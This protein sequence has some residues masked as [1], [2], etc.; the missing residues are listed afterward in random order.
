VE[1][2]VSSTQADEQG[3]RVLAIISTFNEGDVI[4]H[5]IRH[6]VDN[7]VEVYVIDNRSTDD[8]VVE[9]RK[10]LGR[11]VLEVERFPGQGGDGLFRWQ[12]I[13]DRKLVVAGDI[14]PDW[15]LHHDADE[16]RYSPWPNTH[17]REAVAL[18]DRHGFNA[19]DF[20]L[21]NF[22]PV[23]DDF[24][25]GEDPNVYFTRYADGPERDRVQ[26]K[27]WKWNADSA[28]LDGGHDVQLPGKK[29]FPIRFILCHYPIRGQAHGSRKV[30]D[31]R[32]GR[33]V[34][35]ERAIGWHIQYDE[36]ESPGHVF[37][38][39]PA[40]LRSFDLDSIRLDV[41]LEQSRSEVVELKTPRPSPG[42]QYDGVL[43]VAGPGEIS[44][45]AWSSAAPDDP[46][47]VDLWASDELLATVR[48][49]LFREDLQQSGIG[50]GRHAFTF[51]LPPA[52]RQR[53]R[54][55]MWANIAGTEIGL[56]RSP[57]M[58]E[59]RESD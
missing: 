33:F 8:T 7:G 20:R 23:D 19:I 37:L 53:R 36:I 30:F 50:S 14:R 27:C 26:V 39:N 40:S 32:K 9:A 48:A 22:P 5:V 29:L 2:R 57:L 1:G 12:D 51:P 18:V 17:L 21:L 31:E 6:L 38:R 11:G 15:V 41:Q 43:D 59:R 44:G 54:Y 10:W 24:Q 3:I 35:E 52:L 46:V 28:F 13:L 16:I 4:G 55:C 25:P 34:D 56:Q 47:D 58:L 49:D 42:V 45:W